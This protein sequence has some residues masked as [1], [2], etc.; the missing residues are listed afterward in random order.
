MDLARGGDL[1]NKILDEVNI[2]MSRGDDH[3]PGLGQSELATRHVATQLLEGMGY[4]HSFGIIHR[5]MKLENVL[6]VRTYAYPGPAEKNFP[7]P[8][9]VHDVKITDFGLSKNMRLGERWMFGHALGE[10]GD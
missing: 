9:E 10:F 2:S 6:L 8:S 5:D 7:V 1:H 4:M 3:F